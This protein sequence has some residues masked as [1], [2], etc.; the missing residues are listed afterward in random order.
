MATPRIGQNGHSADGKAGAVS[1][2]TVREAA[3][4][5]SMAVGINEGADTGVCPACGAT[6]FVPSNLMA[7]LISVHGQLVVESE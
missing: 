1:T 4:A 6:F 3:D 7:H 2:A 5:A